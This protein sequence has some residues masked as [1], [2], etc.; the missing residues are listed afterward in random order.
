MS[1]LII[2]DRVFELCLKSSSTFMLILVKKKKKT[3][4]TRL[5]QCKCTVIA[6]NNTINNRILCAEKH[7]SIFE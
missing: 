7:N 3:L 2:S 5:K 1:L 6:N 4:P